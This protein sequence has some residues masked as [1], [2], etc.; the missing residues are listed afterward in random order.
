M[1]KK[2]SVPDYH[3]VTKDGGKTW[4]ER[5]GR[6]KVAFGIKSISESDKQ[7]EMMVKNSNI[8]NSQRIHVVNRLSQFI[9][10]R[11]QLIQH[12]HTPIGDID[13]SDDSVEFRNFWHL[14]LVRGRELIDE[15]GRK[16]RVCFDLKQSIP[17][18]NAEKFRSL[19]NILQ[20]EVK[21][22]ND[23]QELIKVIE[24]HKDALIEFIELRNRDKTHGDTIAMA[25]YI[26]PEGIPWG[27]EINNKGNQKKYVLVD[28]LD[29]SYKTIID[30]ARAILQ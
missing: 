3:L 12:L 5:P 16:I 24:N 11:A 29:S 2:I 28:Y 30:F 19:Q 6:L 17:G 25:P 23:L 22:R 26:S 4:E 9:D 7:A 10:A 21:K 14:Y 8:P 1:T 27:G 13:V 18:L 15:I 20:Q